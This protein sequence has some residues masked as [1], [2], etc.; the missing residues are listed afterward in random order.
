MDVLHTRRSPNCS[1]DTSTCTA[2]KLQGAGCC[3]CKGKHKK[4]CSV[5]ESGHEQERLGRA[6]YCWQQSPSFMLGKADS[7]YLSRSR[8]LNAS[9]AGASQ[10]LSCHHTSACTP[11]IDI[12]AASSPI[13]VVVEAILFDSLFRYQSSSP[14][15]NDGPAQHS[16]SFALFDAGIM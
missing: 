5:G 2:K 14:T 1:D 8:N 4:F 3:R 9:L 7:C 15:P 12:G 6:P 16:R 10:F 11:F 13:G